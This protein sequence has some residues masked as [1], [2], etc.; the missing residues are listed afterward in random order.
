[1]MALRAEPV[2]AEESSRDKSTP[3]H[4]CEARKKQE[5]PSTASEADG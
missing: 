4:Q 1:M 2:S 5:G 3:R